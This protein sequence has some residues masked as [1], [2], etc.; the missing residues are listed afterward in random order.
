M[1]DE[2]VFDDMIAKIVATGKFRKAAWGRID[3]PFPT[4]GATVQILRVGFK[5]NQLHGGSMSDSE[6]TVTYHLILDYYNANVDTRR[7]RIL[8]YEGILINLLNI[9]QLGGLTQPQK[10][11]LEVGA[12]DNTAKIA[13]GQSR[14][15][16]TGQFSYIVNPIDGINVDDI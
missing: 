1:Q 8:R 15:V 6:R 10:T 16:L 7:R 5:T 9:K 13:T 2:V 4:D 14:T 11:F 12:D 3:E